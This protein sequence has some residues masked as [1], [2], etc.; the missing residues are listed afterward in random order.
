[1]ANDNFF[2]ILK[3]IT[4]IKGRCYLCLKKPLGKSKMTYGKYHLERSCFE[5]GSL[6]QNH[7]KK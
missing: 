6:L 5:K 1:M 4:V 2:V 7:F 3:K